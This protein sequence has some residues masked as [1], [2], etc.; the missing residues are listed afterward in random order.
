MSR[1]PL[2]YEILAALQ[3]SPRD[4][5]AGWTLRAVVERA[6]VEVAEDEFEAACESL[7]QA[8]ALDF[9]RGGPSRRYRLPPNPD[10]D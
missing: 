2:E 8:G 7:V 9:E 4:A 6:G 10:G 5:I 3:N 1:S